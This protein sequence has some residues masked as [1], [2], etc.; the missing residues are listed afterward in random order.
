MSLLLVKFLYCPSSRQG[1][2][3][4]PP[5]RWRLRLSSYDYMAIAF[6]YKQNKV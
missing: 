5:P 4:V 2:Y 6:K 1:F 3:I